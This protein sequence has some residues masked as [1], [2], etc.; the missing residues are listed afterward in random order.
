MSDRIPGSVLVRTVAVLWLVA[1]C[2]GTG[3]GSPV[4]MN[5]AMGTL[6]PLDT[7][8]VQPGTIVISVLGRSTT[9]FSAAFDTSGSV[10]GFFTMKGLPDGELLVFQVTGQTTPLS[11]MELTSS[12]AVPEI[13]ARLLETVRLFVVRP[14]VSDGSWPRM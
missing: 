7:A 2:G 5:G 1:G 13:R 8:T 6:S 3:P 10:P 4:S 12:G 11:S 9:E 14:N